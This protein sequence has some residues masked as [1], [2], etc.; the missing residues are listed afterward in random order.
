MSFSSEQPVSTVYA[1]TVEFVHIATLVETYEMPEGYPD[2]VVRLALVTC[3]TSARC[4]CDVPITQQ[5]AKLQAADAHRN[6]LTESCT[7]FP[8]GSEAGRL[9]LRKTKAAA[10]TTGMYSARVIHSGTCHG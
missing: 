9:E 2:L 5:R 6:Y 1:P 3:V 7:G 10:A 4:D 8:F